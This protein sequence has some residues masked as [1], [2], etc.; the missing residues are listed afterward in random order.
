MKAHICTGGPKRKIRI[1]GKPYLFEEHPYCGPLP[2]RA[3]GDARPLGAAHP[4]WTAVTEWWQAG[5]RIDRDGWCVWEL[6]P[7]K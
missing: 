5:R 6:A 1:D 4:F 3:D 2:V 7:P